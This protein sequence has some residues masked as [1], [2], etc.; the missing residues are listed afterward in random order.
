MA[1]GISIYQSTKV[2]DGFS[3]CFRQDKAE[4]THCK[5]LHGYALKFKIWFEGALDENNWVVDFGSFKREIQH[6]KN[7]TGVFLNGYCLKDWMSYMFDHTTIISKDDPH[8]EKFRDLDKHNIIQLREVDKVG[9]E[10]FADLVFHHADY[11]TRHST[12]NRVKVVKVECFE[13]EKNS[14]I[15]IQK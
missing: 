11:Y 13:N 6:L 12:K 5:Y 15:C 9:C 3:A 8:I 10:R 7:D 2:F 14:A 4:H 1:H